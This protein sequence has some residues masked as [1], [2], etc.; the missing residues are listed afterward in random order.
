V[1]VARPSAAVA[2][3]LERSAW[4][5]RRCWTCSTSLGESDALGAVAIAVAA[6]RVGTG[7]V[8]E[9]LVVGIERGRGYA[10]VLAAP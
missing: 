7:C 9:A 10:L 5:M 6:A 4:R 3:L 8:A 1:V 2:G